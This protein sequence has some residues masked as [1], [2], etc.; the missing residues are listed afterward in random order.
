MTAATNPPSPPS[1][2]DFNVYE[3]VAVEGHTTRQ[4]AERFKISQT[5]VCQVIRK[6]AAF[7]TAVLPGVLESEMAEAQRLAVSKNVA[8]LRLEHLYQQSMAAWR[9]S[10]G[11]AWRVRE[12]KGGCDVVRTTCKQSRKI[13]FLDQAMK[14][15]QRALELDLPL[16]MCMLAEDDDE[17]DAE[18]EL[19]A[20]D[21]T[22]EVRHDDRRDERPGAE[23]SDDEVREVVLARDPAPV[24]ADQI[25]VETGLGRVLG[26]HGARLVPL[27]EDVVREGFPEELGLGHRYDLLRS[28]W[29]VGLYVLLRASEVDVATRRLDVICGHGVTR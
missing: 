19:A 8:A 7:A 27:L 3:H 5:R 11:E 14:I 16:P 4:A 25:A 24:L 20:N 17:S 15:S 6:V 1:A 10:G 28:I 2:R 26:G 12:S 23:K 21:A 22:D 13:A 29:S 18:D 9:K